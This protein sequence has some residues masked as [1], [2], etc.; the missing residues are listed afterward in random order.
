ME[1]EVSALPEK[2]FSSFSKLQCPLW[3]HRDD[4]AATSWVPAVSRCDNTYESLSTGPT[5]VPSW[6]AQGYLSRTL[7]GHPYR[8]RFW[9]SLIPGLTTKLQSRPPLGIISPPDS[10]LG[11]SS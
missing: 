7:S 2:L 4:Q 3:K 9:P 8:N 5:Q 11:P 1:E 10:R 6:S